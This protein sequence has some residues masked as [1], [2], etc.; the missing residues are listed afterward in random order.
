MTMTDKFTAI[1]AVRCSKLHGKNV[2]IIIVAA[3]NKTAFKA[4]FFDH[5]RQSR[6]YL[7]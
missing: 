1:A 3:L 6:D 7:R 2:P 5:C 4:L